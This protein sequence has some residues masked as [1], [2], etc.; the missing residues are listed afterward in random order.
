M[1]TRSTAYYNN[2][3]VQLLPPAVRTASVVSNSIDTQNFDSM[4][5][6]VSIGASGDT[7]NATNRVEMVVQESSDNVNW[8]AA[9]SSSL[10]DVVVGGQSPSGTMGVL[11]AATTAGQLF[12]IGYIG[13]LRYVR[14]AL[15]NYGTTSNGTA[16]E[17]MAWIAR[18]HNYPLNN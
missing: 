15:N 12:Y 4:A 6:M 17:V 14:V 5:L 1:T 9:A 18:P 8:T 13:G 10:T 11:N 2:L 3:P 7:L 16:M